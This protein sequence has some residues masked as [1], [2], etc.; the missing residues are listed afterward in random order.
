LDFHK[1]LATPGE[2]CSPTLKQY[3]FHDIIGESPL[4]KMSIAIAEKAAA[5]RRAY[6]WKL[7]DA[8]QAALALTHHLRLCTRNTKDFD[9]KEHAFVEVPYVF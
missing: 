3:S 4:I 5:L 8:F 2:Q 9:P 7:P 6:G 1:K